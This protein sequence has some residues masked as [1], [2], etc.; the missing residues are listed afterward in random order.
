MTRPI[1]WACGVLASVGVAATV[2]GDR[3]AGLAP[4]APRPT[5]PAVQERRT[6]T[7]AEAPSQVS[8]FHGG[9]RVETI[10]GDRRGHFS[11]E[12]RID[13]SRIG[14]LVDTGASLVALR[15]EDAER[16]GIHVKRS[17]FTGRTNTAN[18]QGIYAPIRIRSLRIGDIEVRDVEAAIIPRGQLSTNLLGMSFLKRLHSFDIGN[19]RITLKG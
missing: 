3:L 7:P 15:E 4:S 2:A 9:W 1:V 12:A 18:G 11:A 14:F 8:T 19:N 6:A 5:A 10:Q 16:V 17:D 13:G